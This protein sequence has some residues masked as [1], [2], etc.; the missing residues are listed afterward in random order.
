MSTSYVD[1][2]CLQ[3]GASAT[4]KEYTHYP[5]GRRLGAETLLSLEEKE[6]ECDWD[7]G[8]AERALIE[9]RTRPDEQTVQPT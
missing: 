9:Y 5:G 7:R 4:I 8:E 1:A 6:C 3:C 2:E